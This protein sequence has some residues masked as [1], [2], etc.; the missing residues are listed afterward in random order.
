MSDDQFFSDEFAAALEA[1]SKEFN[2]LHPEDDE[3]DGDL[4][5]VAKG[6][7]HNDIM[8]FIGAM[9]ES[10][11]ADLRSPDEEDQ[12]TALGAIVQLALLAGMNLQEHRQRELERILGERFT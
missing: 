11:G 6:L 2:S 8:L 7:K 10:Y 9:M 4:Q 1:G 12:A 5:M 3:Q